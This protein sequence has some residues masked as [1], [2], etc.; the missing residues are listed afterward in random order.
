MQAK[1]LGGLIIGIISVYWF[2]ILSKKQT[3][4]QIYNTCTKYKKLRT[5]HEYIK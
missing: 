2:V 5:V 3:R 4:K 1:K